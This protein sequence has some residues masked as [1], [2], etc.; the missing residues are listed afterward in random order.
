MFRI[1]NSVG[2]K[3]G[4]K[5]I[6]LLKSQSAVAWLEAFN[7]LSDDIGEIYNKQYKE[8]YLFGAS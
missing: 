6:Y 4:F 8:S 2:W 3:Q 7:L 1:Q 5:C